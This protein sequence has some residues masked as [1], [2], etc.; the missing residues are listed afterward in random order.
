MDDVSTGGAAPLPTDPASAPWHLW[1]VGLI[2][3]LWN[4]FGG[5]DYVMTQTRN[6]DYFASISDQ[7]GMSAAEMTAFF[8]SFPA[9]ASALWAIGVWGSILGSILLLARSRHA[10]TA[11]LVSLAGAV[12]SFI[13]QATIDLP[14]AMEAGTMNKVMPFVII[15]AVVLQWIYARRMRGAGVLR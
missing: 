9:W 14:P 13:Y 15:G 11:F 10:A 8:D 3:L 1:A 7:M 6:P 5:Y 4:A 2:S 12:L